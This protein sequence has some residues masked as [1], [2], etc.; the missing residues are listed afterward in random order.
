MESCYQIELFTPQSSE[1]PRRTDPFVRQ[2]CLTEN[3]ARRPV[4]AA[5]NHI[6]LEPM[7]NSLPKLLISKSILLSTALKLV[8]WTVVSLI[9]SIIQQLLE[10]S[11]I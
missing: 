7:S 6:H 8:I 10:G 9:T 3:P 11:I 4:C 5:I 1:Q 2:P